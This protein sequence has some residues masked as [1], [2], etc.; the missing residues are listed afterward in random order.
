M[1]NHWTKRA[2]ENLM[3][4]ARFM[5]EYGKQFGLAAYGT[6]GAAAAT[7]ACM[8]AGSDHTL[9]ATHME[10]MAIGLGFVG[11]VSG[12]SLTVAS[13]IADKIVARNDLGDRKTWN[14]L[15]DL[16]AKMTGREAKDLARVVGQVA[17]DPHKDSIMRDILGSS[18]DKSM[19]ELYNELAS[20]TAAPTQID[21][22]QPK[23][24]EFDAP[25]MAPS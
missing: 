9:V 14:N 22:R 23:Q 25:M 19:M 17:N 2:K 5:S 1:S 11:A 10:Q 15:S 7:A 13:T 6:I 24:E 18:R 16:M 21:R 8:A 20:E 12:A 3:D 4:T